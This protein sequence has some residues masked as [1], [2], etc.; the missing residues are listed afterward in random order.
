MKLNILLDLISEIGS[1]SR[2]VKQLKD[3][4]YAVRVLTYDTIRLRVE[5]PLDKK[6]LE[7]AINIL[8]DLCNTLN[9]TSSFWKIACFEIW[10]E[11]ERA[12]FVRS[13]IMNTNDIC[14]YIRKGMKGSAIY[15]LAWV[16]PCIKT[17]G[18]I[19]PE[20]VTRKCIERVED[21]NN[22]CKLM[23]KFLSSIQLIMQAIA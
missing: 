3:K 12:S 16:V 13:G 5:L 15:K 9:T 7:N 22:N 19:L 20:S 11:K 1:T 8:H 17:M 14:I 4:G 2:L 21:L 10:V 6:T 23:I 18:A